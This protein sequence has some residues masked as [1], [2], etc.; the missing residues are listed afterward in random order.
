[1]SFE[2]NPEN[3]RKLRRFNL[4]MG[5]VHLLQGAFLLIGALTIDTLKSETYPIY[6]RFLEFNEST[7]MLE[8]VLKP[9]WEVPFVAF[10]AIFLLLTSMFHF[11][12]ASPKLNNV[13]NNDLQKGFNKFRWI[14]YAITSSI[15]IVLIGLLFGINELGTIILLFGINAVMN[16]TGLLMET[17]NTNKQKTNWT[18]FVVGSIAGV[19]PWIVMFLYAFG[20]SVLSSVP[21]FVFAIF[22]SYFVFFNLFP[23][24][25]LLQYKKVGKCKDYLYGEKMYIILSLTS[26]T[27]LAWLVFAGIM[28]P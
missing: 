5:L 20:N 24:N 16:L 19:V 9:L 2:N 27:I 23:V 12:I 4:I 18:S 3:F 6:T 8:N 13:Y 1:M 22:A 17:H 11:L 21:W 25:M 10:V 26:K 28:Q 7:Q 14:E 15:M